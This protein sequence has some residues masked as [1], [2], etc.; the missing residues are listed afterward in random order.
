MI[1]LGQVALQ[2]S[3]SGRSSLGWE[4]SLLTPTEIQ[5]RTTELQYK[6]GALDQELRLVMV[7]DRA[8]F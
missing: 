6:V 7:T 2:G 8:M 5:H 4:G 1:Y 3:F